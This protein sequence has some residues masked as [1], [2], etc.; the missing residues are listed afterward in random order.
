MTQ[1]A[2]LSRI[3]GGHRIAAGSPP[4]SIDNPGERA[5][6]SWPGSPGIRSLSLVTKA[7]ILDATEMR[8]IVRRMAGELIEVRGR[9]RQPDADR[10]PHPRRAARRAAGGGHLPARGQARARSARSTSRSIATICRWSRRSRWCARA[11]SRSRSQDRTLVLCDDV[12][13]TGRT[14]RAALDALL[15]Y[16]RPEGGPARGAH[17][18]RL[19]GVP[20]PCRRRRPQGPD[21]RD[22]GDQGQ[23]RGHRR[24][25]EGADPGPQARRMTV[26]VDRPA[27]RRRSAGRSARRPR[28]RIDR[29]APQGP[30]RHRRALRRGDRAH[31]LDRRVVRRGRPSAGEEGPDA[32]RQDG[33]ESLLRAFDPHARL[34]RDRRAAA[35]GGR[36]QLQHRRLVAVEGR[37]P[38][39]HDA[40]HRVDVPRFRR[41]AP[42]PPGV[43]AMLARELACGVVNAGDGSH[44]H[45]TQALLDALTIRR[46]KG[47]DRRP[48]GGDGRRHRPQP[49]RALEHPPADPAGGPRAG[50]GTAHHAAGGD[51]RAWASRSATRS[52][53]RSPAPTSS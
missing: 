50:G 43:P 46:R 38:A 37:D 7:T 23:L 45:P 21:L 9:P 48:D 1:R 51:R 8:R 41:R 14:V 34:L 26:P 24:G 39:R 52:K 3:R 6:P 40:Q 31:P 49:R 20:D 22:R 5:I 2:S 29:L 16:G 15:D 42:R 25:V 32:A 11:T 4:F 17:R 12:L 18:S 30:A 27:I 19:A 35:F 47:T 13:Y 53:R 33:G 28:R 36:G 44:E 10:D